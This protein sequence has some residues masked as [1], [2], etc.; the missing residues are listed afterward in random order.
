MI[1]KCILRIAVEMAAFLVLCSVEKAAVSIEIR[2]KRTAV[3]QAL[4]G[5]DQ[6][7]LALE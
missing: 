2:G 3:A 4:A 5:L 1:L 6:V 7:F